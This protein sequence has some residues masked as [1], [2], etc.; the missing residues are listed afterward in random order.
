MYKRGKYHII[1]IRII[2]I[3]VVNLIISGFKPRFEHNLDAHF[4]SFCWVHSN[5]CLTLRVTMETLTSLL[6]LFYTWLEY[7][8]LTYHSHIHCLILVAASTVYTWPV[9]LL[10]YMFCFQ[11]C[12]PLTCN[13]ALYECPTHVI[14]RSHRKLWRAGAGRHV[15]Y[16]R[17]N[18][19]DH[20][21]V[22]TTN[23][24]PFVYFVIKLAT[25]P[26]GHRGPRRQYPYLLT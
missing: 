20:S 1:P 14:I 23:A 26:P 17:K 25:T 4:V 2:A 16:W 6:L 8:D 15:W 22:R 19:S 18:I 5:V 24:L 11:Q 7:A 12:P 10:Y 21:G 3:Y 13:V 9:T